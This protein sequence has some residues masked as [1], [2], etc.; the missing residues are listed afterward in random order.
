MTSEAAKMAFSGNMHIDARVIEVAC[1]NYDKMLPFR[2]LRLFGGRH[3]LEG[4]PNHCFWQ[5]TKDTSIV[6]RGCMTLHD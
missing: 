1:N 5:T 2:P 6:E 3:G 4:C